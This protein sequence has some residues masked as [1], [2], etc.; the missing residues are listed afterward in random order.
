MS[1]VA[2]ARMY[3]VTPAAAAAWRVLF[4]AVAR[5]SGVPLSYI[6]HAAPA[7]LDS[8]WARDDLGAAF[9]C[10]Y[11]FAMAARKPRL[12]AAPVPAPPR[13]GG[14][15][16]YCTD[17]IV[18]ADS[19][20]GRLS[21]T[22]GGRIGWT[23]AHSQS[24]Y[25]ALRHHLLAHQEA[26]PLYRSWVGPL[27]TPRRVIEA[28]LADE[29]DAGPLDSYVHDLLQHHDP[30]TAA[31]LR[32]VDS[33]A[34]TPIPPLIAAPSVD[35]ETM[36]RVREALLACDGEPEMRATLDALLISRFAE[37]DASGYDLYLRWAREA[38]VGGV[39]AP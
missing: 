36:L 31:R 17:F 21:D 5:R 10:G 12:L 9:M 3:A 23:V 28:V 11:P 25:N 22:F 33:T 20:F 26:Q 2:N 14:R 13:Y 24:G 30:A 39:P 4:D 29:I 34:M 16:Q 27:V 35:D 8:L 6:D 32:V 19:A 1:L 18:R 15:P 37:I 7:P 38:D